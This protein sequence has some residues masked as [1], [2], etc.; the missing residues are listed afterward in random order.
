MCRP[1]QCKVCSKTTWAGCGNHIAEVKASVPKDQWCPGNHSQTE[2]ANAQTSQ[3]GFLSRL[4]S[5]S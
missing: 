3:P 5:R 4:F 2:I 1:V